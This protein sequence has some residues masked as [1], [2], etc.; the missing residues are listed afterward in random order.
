MP[1][2]RQHVPDE[3]SGVPLRSGHARELGIGTSRMRREDVD[4]PYTGV[5]G[6]GLNLSSVGDR[7][8][9]YA[10]LLLDGQAFS[11]GTALALWG[12]PLPEGDDDLH[13]SVLFPRTPPRGI[14]VRGHSLR[15]IETR[16]LGGLPVASPAF[17]WC[18]AAASLRR[19]DLVAA[20]DALLTG[21][22]IG[23]VR[24]PGVVAID[25]LERAAERLRG[26]PGSARVAWAVP[27]LRTGVD[28]RPESL[29]RLVCVRSRLPEPRVDHAVPLGRRL[30]LHADLAWP[31][32][33]V[34]LEYEGDVHRVDR[35][36]WMRDLE[37][38][39]LFEDAG[40]RV[41]RVTASDLFQ[42]PTVLT[43]R[44]RR[45]LAARTP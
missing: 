38:R 12:A 1:R 10:P 13:L 36:T 32:A 14:G 43:S 19:E 9:A 35:T 41:V 21:P 25:E 20:G 8:A 2:P 11:H 23:G 40:W 17:A 44:L 5:V 7:C 28:S 24:G 39:E 29:L 16:M 34:A 15:H 42:R 6:F 30:I 45:L 4:R 37:R 31:A 33:R 3:L 22:R 27:R 26:S 18:Q